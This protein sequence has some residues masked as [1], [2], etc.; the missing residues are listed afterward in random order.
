MSN[1]IPHY[2]IGQIL[3][4]IQENNQRVIFLNQRLNLAIDQDGFL[5]EILDRKGMM[6]GWNRKERIISSFGHKISTITE[7]Q[8]HRVC[9]HMSEYFGLSKDEL[10]KDESSIPFN[11]IF[12]SKFM[13]RICTFCDHKVIYHLIKIFKM[14]KFDKNRVPF[15]NSL[16]L[17]HGCRTTID[18]TKF[19]KTI[20]FIIGIYGLT[21]TELC[22][23][24]LG[25]MFP[26]GRNRIQEVDKTYCAILGQFGKKYDLINQT[27]FIYRS[28]EC[29]NRF[30]EFDHDVEL[31]KHIC[32]CFEVNV[33][34]IRN[35]C[36]CTDENDSV[37]FLEDGLL[38]TACFHNHIDIIKYLIEI[39]DFDNN[40]YEGSVL[41]KVIN[42]LWKRKD[43][44][45]VLTTIKK[46]IDQLKVKLDEDQI[47]FHQT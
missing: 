3:L 44:P 38:Y 32:D 47:G 27:N 25:T 15:V 35:G 20:D 5:K 26:Y 14:P 43:D 18:K 39:Y 10:F 40:D 21:K 41:T 13:I 22:D 19:L 42:M 2:S 1:I 7:D 23:L 30:M 28:I 46:L 24:R 4:Q 8:Y 36:N 9:L 11:I 33:N 12:P 34:S 45:V 16:L 29:L 17:N 31:F 37:F 6:I